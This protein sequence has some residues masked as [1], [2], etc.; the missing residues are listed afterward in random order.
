MCNLE[1]SYMEQAMNMNHI[2]WSNRI[3]NANLK[4]TPRGMLLINMVS[5]DKAIVRENLFILNFFMWASQ[6]CT[7]KDGKCKIVHTNI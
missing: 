7:F 4:W 5:L 2:Q 6:N 1:S 3:Y